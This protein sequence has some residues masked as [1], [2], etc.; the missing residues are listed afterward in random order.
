MVKFE[1]RPYFQIAKNLNIGIIS[2]D[3]L[4]VAEDFARKLYGWAISPRGRKILQ[5][6]LGREKYQDNLDEFLDECNIESLNQDD[7]LL[8]TYAMKA[9]SNLHIRKCDIPRLNGLYVYLRFQ[10]LE[11]ISHFHRIVKALNNS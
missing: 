8:L 2:G 6:S 3:S 4:I 10:N 11:L 5:L 9:N 1:D 7:G